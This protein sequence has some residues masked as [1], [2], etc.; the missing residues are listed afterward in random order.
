M[1]ININVKTNARHER[2]EN[3]GNGNFKIHV[4]APAKEG[5]ANKRLLQLLAQHFSV[6]QSRIKLR[7][8]EKS[9]F[10]QVEILK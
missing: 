8:G 9:R 4:A 6:P 3:L 7:F 10:K 2:I 5:R 1:Y